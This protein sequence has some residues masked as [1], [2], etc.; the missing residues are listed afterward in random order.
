MRTKG[1]FTDCGYLVKVKMHQENTEAQK[2]LGGGRLML[3]GFP[4]D[5]VGPTTKGHQ[6]GVV[7]A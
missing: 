1:C 2:A 6:E 3:H 4:S 7:E 5:P